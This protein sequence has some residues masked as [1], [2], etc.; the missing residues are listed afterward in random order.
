M[1]RNGNPAK[2]GLKL[3]WFNCVV[4]SQGV[5]NGNP[6]KQGLKHA[7]AVVTNQVMSK[8]ET[9]IQQNKD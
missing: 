7:V 9:E 6:A 4:N 5:R 2:Q 8:S 1:V 3:T